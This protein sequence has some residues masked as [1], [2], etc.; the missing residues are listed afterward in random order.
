[1][2]LPVAGF[3]GISSPFVSLHVASCCPVFGHLV[4]L[5]L[6]SCGFLLPGSEAS[7]LPLSHFMSAFVSLHVASCSWVF[8]HLVSLCLPSCGFLFLGFWACRLPLSP[9]MWLPVAGFRGISSPFVSL[10]VASCCRIPRHVVSLCLPSCLPSSPFMWLDVAGF[11]ASRL[12]LSPFMSAFVSLHVASCCRVARHLVSLCL[13][14]CSPL[15]PFMWLPVAGLR[16]I[17]SPFVS[18]HVASCCRVP[19]HVVSLHVSLCLPLCGFLLPLCKFFGVVVVQV[20][21]TASQ[22]M[23]FARFC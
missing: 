11:C 4:S 5:C 12:P 16:G 23:I 3:L 21:R 18:L 14:W 15:S 6:L 17:L 13:P 9:F 7:R 1:M 22:R 20:F 10:H 8:G 19:G 2:W